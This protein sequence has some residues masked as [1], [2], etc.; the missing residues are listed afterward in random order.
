MAEDATLRQLFGDSIALEGNIAAIGAS[1]DDQTAENA[2]ATY[3]YE[4]VFGVWTQQTKLTVADDRTR[5]FS[6]SVSLDGATLAVGSGL[7]APGPNRCC[8]GVYMF[9]YDGDQW[10]RDA[11][12]SPAS[13][14]DEVHLVSSVKAP[15]SPL[16]LQN[17]FRYQVPFRSVF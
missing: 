2:G 15:L 12:L 11:F 7:Q 3:I 14:D 16:L 9:E 4:R 10:K 8:G 5:F 17:R 13:N 6:R 1:G